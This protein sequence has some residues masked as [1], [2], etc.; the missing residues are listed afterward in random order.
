MNRILEILRAVFI[1]PFCVSCGARICEHDV[2]L[3]EPCQKRYMTE[4]GQ[5]CS[6]CGFPAPVCRCGFQLKGKKLTVYHAALYNPKNP[7]VVGK[8]VFNAKQQ[9]LRDNFDFI[10]A[11]CVSVLK[12]RLNLSQGD[13]IV[14]WM[15]RRRKAIAKY[16]HDQSREMAKRIAGKLNITLV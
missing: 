10:A 6:L 13:F 3:C 1:V 8:I 9:N 12:S 11:E 7:G 2:P 4:R 5:G 15:P 14:T 16:G